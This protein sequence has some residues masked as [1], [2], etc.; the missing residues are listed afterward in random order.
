L[1]EH[2]YPFQSR[3]ADIDGANVHYLDEGDG[4]VLLPTPERRRWEATFPDHRTVL[5]DG[6]GHHIQEDAPAEIIA[7]IRDWD[8]RGARG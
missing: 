6:A 3:Y 4:P 8:S 2:L 5:L 1:P 7:A